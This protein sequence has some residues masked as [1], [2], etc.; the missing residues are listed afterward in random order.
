M[1]FRCFFIWFPLYE[2][3]RIEARAKN[4][5]ELMKTAHLW[6]DSA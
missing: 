6:P 4:V 2:F 1:G 5:D 3:A